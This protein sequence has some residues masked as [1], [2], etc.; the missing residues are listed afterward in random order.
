MGWS[1]LLG[2]FARGLAPAIGQTLQEGSGFKGFGKNFL[3]NTMKN[4]MPSDNQSPTGPTAPSPIDNFLGGYKKIPGS[5]Q[6]DLSGQGKQYTPPFLG[7]GVPTPPTPATSN[8]SL[9]GDNGQIQQPQEWPPK[10]PYS[11]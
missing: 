7:P 5:G 1:D 6:T 11:V 9:Q 3:G 2:T 10:N 4:F 8:Q